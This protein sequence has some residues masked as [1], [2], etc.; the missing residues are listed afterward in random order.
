MDM[1]FLGNQL[2]YIQITLSIPSCNHNFFNV[3]LM[4]FL[5]IRCLTDV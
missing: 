5:K 4:W 3:L 1:H 2:K